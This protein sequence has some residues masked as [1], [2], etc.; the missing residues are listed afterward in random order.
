MNSLRLEKLKEM[1]LQKPDDAFLKFALAQEYVNIGKDEEAKKYFDLLLEHFPAYVATYY[2]AG[3]LYERM[4]EPKK[5]THIYKSGIAIAKEANDMKNLG[6][7]NE[8][9]QLLDE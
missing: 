5:A 2:H 6:E 8:A 3:K 1:E 4:N 9:L 7:L